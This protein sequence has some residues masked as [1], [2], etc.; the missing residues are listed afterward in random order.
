MND[1]ETAPFQ[2]VSIQS[3]DQTSI[4]PMDLG[5]ICKRRHPWTCLANPALLNQNPD[6]LWWALPIR[7]ARV[8]SPNLRLG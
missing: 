6:G 4:V 3:A 1:K 2:G 8:A 5:L 7:E